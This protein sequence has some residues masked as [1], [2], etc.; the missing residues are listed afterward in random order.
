METPKLESSIQ[1]VAHEMD[2]MSGPILVQLKC[3]ETGLLQDYD[4]T[5]SIQ[6]PPRNGRGQFQDFFYM[7]NNCLMFPETLFSVTADKGTNGKKKSP[8]NQ[9]IGCLQ[10]SCRQ[11]GFTLVAGNNYKTH[12]GMVVHHLFHCS[13]YKHKK[14][15]SVQQA[16]RK[17]KCA[18]SRPL[19]SEQR[20]P[21]K[22][23]VLQLTDTQT[24][25]FPKVISGCASHCGHLKLPPTNLSERKKSQDSIVGSFED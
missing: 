12:N 15:S 23:E 1:A 19:P 24:W 22:F 25:F 6:T 4:L 9:I 14:A 2:W 8:K 18:S 10:A 13:R 3:S 11:A 20:C 21:F 17:R 7:T 5:P 16:D